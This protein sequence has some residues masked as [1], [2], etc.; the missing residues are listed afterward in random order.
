MNAHN[1]AVALGLFVIF[2][3]DQLDPRGLA[4]PARVNILA[5]ASQAVE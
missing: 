3:D 1:R 2:V 5:R 4:S